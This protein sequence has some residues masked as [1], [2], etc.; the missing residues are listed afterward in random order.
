MHAALFFP[1]LRAKPV[2]QLR[3]S[4]I[5]A[6]EEPLLLHSQMRPPAANLALG[7]MFYWYSSH[8]FIV[9]S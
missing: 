5:L 2:S 8:S 4:A 9:T 6:N 7:M 1:T 3:R